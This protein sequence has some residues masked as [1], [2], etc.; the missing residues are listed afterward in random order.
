MSRFDFEEVPQGP[1]VGDVSNLNYYELE[2]FWTEKGRD[3][4]VLVS[5]SGGMDSTTLAYF[6]RETFPEA[7]FISFE[8]GSKHNPYEAAALEDLSLDLGVKIPR[9]NLSTA[10]AGIESNLMAAGGDIPHGHYA[11]SNMSL[12]VVPGRNLIMASVLAG[13]A[14]SRG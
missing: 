12:T 10:F 7:Q 2:S 13:I 6:A 4:R 5:L 3:K 9:I 14:E 1:R 11:Q 8:Y